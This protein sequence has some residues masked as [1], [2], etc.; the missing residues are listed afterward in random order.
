MLHALLVDAES[1]KSQIPTRSVMGLHGSRQ[2]KRAL[3]VQILHAA[4]HHRQLQCDDPGHFNRAAERDLPVSLREVEVAD[5][6]FGAGNVDREEDFAAA[7][8]VLDVA[9]AAVLGAAGYGSRSFF[10]D[11]LFELAGC[12]ARVDVLGLGWLGDDALEFGG[13]DEMGFATVPLG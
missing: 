11:F 10:A 1:L 7:A 3:H 4:L 13:A 12:G 8:Q 6:E 5:A 2:E 9:I